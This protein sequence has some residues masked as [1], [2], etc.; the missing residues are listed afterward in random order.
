LGFQKPK[1][2]SFGFRVVGLHFE[3]LLKKFRKEKEKEKIN[4]KFE[5]NYNPHP[6]PPKNPL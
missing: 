1:P 3:L 4:D 2:S 6:L 5:I